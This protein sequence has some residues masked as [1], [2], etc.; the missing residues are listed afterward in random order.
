V[1]VVSSDVIWVRFAR[2]GL[3]RSCLRLLDHGFFPDC[4]DRSPVDLDS[5]GF[6]TS[7]P[8][9]ADSEG[10]TPADLSLADPILACVGSAGNIV[11]DRGPLDSG[12]ASIDPSLTVTELAYGSPVNFRVAGVGRVDTFPADLKADGSGPTNKNSLIPDK[13]AVDL[14]GADSFDSIP[15]GDADNTSPPVRMSRFTFTSTL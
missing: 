10:D 15:S 6:D 14:V 12:P 2:W 5:D 7:G 3:L 1:G 9:F 4:S 8:T 13:V 11:A